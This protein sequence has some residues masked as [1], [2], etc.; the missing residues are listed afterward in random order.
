[1]RRSS[2][3][4]RDEAFLETGEYSRVER[5]QDEL[6]VPFPKLDPGLSLRPGLE[7]NRPDAAD[8]S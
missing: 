7:P 5:F 4:I 6:A 1:M 2:E 8:A 3:N